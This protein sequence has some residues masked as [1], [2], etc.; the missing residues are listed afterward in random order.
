MTAIQ[1]SPIDVA[2]N[3]SKG[4]KLS[5]TLGSRR[6]KIFV[7][8][9]AI[10][11]TV[12]TFGLFV[13]SFR[14]ERQ[15]K[16]TGWWK[17]FTNPQ[18]TLDNYQA[19][20]GK[21]SGIDLGRFFLNSFKIVLPS[22]F[23]SVALA[24]LAS[25]AL[26]WME[27][28]G[29]DWLFIAIVGLLVVPLQLAIIPLLKLFNFGAHIGS[30]PIFPSLPFKGTVFPI[31][32]AHSIFGMPFCIFILKNFISALPSELIEAGK[33]DGAGH[34]TIF[35]RIV[36]PLSVPSIASLTI[37]QFI[38]IWNDFYVGK[39]FGGEENKPVIAALVSLSG[40]RGQAWELLTA[41]AFI[42]A[43]VPLVVFFS[44]QRY[45]VKGLLAGSVKG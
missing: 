4:K 6:G 36:L 3:A 18:F 43:I 26:S 13:T 2:P 8:I 25:Y 30:V 44:L 29:R 21:E 12:P 34:L 31:W 40:S 22:V 33:I 1:I 38:F 9:I 19:V 41:A 15:I 14:P 20:L 5:A 16:S 28:K 23:I 17:V 10:L 39:I 24:A 37:F 32:I 45:F 7:W 11:W 35:R 27:F 42:S